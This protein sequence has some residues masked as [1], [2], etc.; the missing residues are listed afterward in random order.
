M[1]KLQLLITYF[2][3]KKGAFNKLANAFEPDNFIIGLFSGILISI[4]LFL[5]FI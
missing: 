1:Q 5:L 3:I 2:I 4:A